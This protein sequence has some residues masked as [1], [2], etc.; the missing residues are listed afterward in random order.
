MFS[1]YLSTCYIM[2]SLTVRTCVQ[3]I[4]GR[5]FSSSLARKCKEMDP[6]Q[7]SLLDEKCFLVDM[8]DKVI[9]HASKR[10]CHLVQNN[11]IPLHRAFSVFLF[12]KKGDLLLQKRSSEKV[13]KH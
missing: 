10:D 7:K 2:L 8:N 1:V 9:G 12:N 6:I 5:N 11:D 13:I 3:K 4:V